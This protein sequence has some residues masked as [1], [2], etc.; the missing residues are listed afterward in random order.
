MPIRDCGRRLIA[1]GGER[2]NSRRPRH[3]SPLNRYPVFHRLHG[4]KGGMNARGKHLPSSSQT[5]QPQAK[6]KNRHSLRKSH[7]NIR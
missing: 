6:R 5:C 2:W 7:P 4:D 3:N 1:Q